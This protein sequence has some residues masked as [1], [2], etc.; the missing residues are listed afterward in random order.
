MSELVART[1]VEKTLY[2]FDKPFDYIVPDHLRARVTVGSRVLVPF[3]RGNKKRQALVTEL[4][5]N[6]AP[7]PRLKSIYSAPDDYP[8]L[9][10]EMTALSD[11]LAKRCYCTRYDVV[12]AMLPVGINFN[13]SSVYSAAKSAPSI[14][15]TD[16]QN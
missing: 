7:D 3:G 16:K 14:E 5:E 8:L 9:T 6:D 10:S 11:T 12:R 13:I 4:F 1:A 15:L 2:S